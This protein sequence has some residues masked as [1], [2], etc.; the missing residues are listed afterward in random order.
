MEVAQNAT[1]GFRLPAEMR[2]YLQKRAQEEHTTVSRYLVMLILMDMLNG[3]K[4]GNT[5]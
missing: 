5:D 1:V 2:T 4:G 3:E